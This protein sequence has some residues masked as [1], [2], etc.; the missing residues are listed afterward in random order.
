MQKYFSFFFRSFSIEI[1]EK[2]NKSRNSKKRKKDL[3]SLEVFLCKNAE[4]KSKSK[5]Y[6]LSSLYVFLSKS[7]KSKKK[8]GLFTLFLI[9]PN[10][11]RS[12]SC[13][14][15]IRRQP[16][17]GSITIKKRNE[18]NEEMKRY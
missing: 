9:F 8:V 6:I 1:P 16:K 17:S 14:H 11:A 13:S 2:N 4:Q 5:K 15:M 10:Y 3:S 12:D 7:S 18:K